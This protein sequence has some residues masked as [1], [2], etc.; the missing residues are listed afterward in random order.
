M[1]FREDPKASDNDLHHELNQNEHK[2][3]PSLFIGKAKYLNS[4]GYI[5]IYIYTKTPMIYFW[6]F[7]NLYIKCYHDKWIYGFHCF[8]RI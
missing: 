2:P 4:Y 5:D 1:I 7:Y 8:D 3:I 6:L